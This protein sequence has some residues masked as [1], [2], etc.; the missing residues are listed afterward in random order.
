MPDLSKNQISTSLVST[1][2]ASELSGYNSDYL[3]RV[4]REGKIKGTQVGRAWLIDKESLL[5]FVESQQERKRELAQQT[6]KVREQEYKTANKTTPV[7][8]GVK[9]ATQK[10]TQKATE[11]ARAVISPIQRSHFSGSA[12]GVQRAHATRVNRPLVAAA[13]ALV[14]T[15]G[16]AYASTAPQLQEMLARMPENIQHVADAVMR[17]RVIDDSFRITDATP[18]QKIVAAEFAVPNAK[19]IS[20]G[21]AYATGAKSNTYAQTF[22]AASVGDSNNSDATFASHFSTEENA[23]VA[24][25]RIALVTDAIAH[26]SHM[27]VSLVQGYVQ[28]GAN[29]FATAHTI[30]D[31]YL[32]MV[33][34]VADSSLATAAVARDVVANA[35]TNTNA[36]LALYERGTYAWVDASH[37]V[38]EVSAGTIYNTGGTIGGL[39]TAAPGAIVH[40]R[41]AL[42]NAWVDRSLAL[43]NAAADSQTAAGT[44]A[45][46]VAD[47]IGSSYLGA[48]DTSGNVVGGAL[49][50][51]VAALPN[52]SEV[53][54]VISAPAQQAVATA[55]NAG[56]TLAAAVPAMP[57]HVSFSTISD[58]TQDTMLGMAG[59]VMAWAD[60]NSGNTQSASVISFAPISWQRTIQR[61]FVAG[62]EIA[63]ALVHASVR[64]IADTFSLPGAFSPE[65][66]VVPFGPTQTIALPQP[67]NLGGANGVALGNDSSSASGSY[68]GGA[69]GP[70]TYIQN[71]INNFSKDAFGTSF[72]DAVLAI[73][74]PY[75]Q[76]SIDS[77]I[78]SVRS[79]GGG[80]TT[81]VTGSTPANVVVQGGSA[82]LASLDVSG[83]T[84]LNTLTTTGVTTLATTTVNGDLNIT[85]TISAGSLAVS[86]ITSN[87]PVIAP[88]FT[89]TSTVATSTFPNLAA[90]NADITNATLGNATST[91]FFTTN[92]S[93]AAAN[94]TNAVFGS[95]VANLANIT[96]ATITNLTGTNS[97]FVNSTTTNATTTNLFA[98]NGVINNAT[99]T[100]LF[101]TNVSGTNATFGN[102][103]TTNLFAT[104]AS[105][106]TGFFDNLFATNAQFVNSTTT[107]ATTTNF[108]ATNGFINTLASAVANIA[109]A[110][111]T[112]LTGTNSQFVNSTTTNSVATNATTTNLTATNASL[113]NALIT[114]GTSTN[115][116]ATNLTGTN[117]QFTNA[118]STNFFSTLGSFT[119]AIFGSFVA[120]LANI[121]TA[122]IT[123]LSGTNSVFVNATTT[124]ATTT[125]LFATNATTTNLVTSNLTGTSAQFTHATTSD[126]A[127]TGTVGSNLI[128]SLNNQ[129]DIGSP[130][131]TWSNGYFDSIHVANFFVASTS[132]DGTASNV[133]SINSDNATADTE[134]SSISF[135]RGSISPNALLT[136]NSTLDRFEFNMPVQ[137]PSLTASTTFTLGT[138]TF[139]SLLGAG[140]SNVGGALT[141]TV[142][143]TSLALDSSYFK[144][145]G[146][147]FGSTAILG[148]TDNNS[149]NI[150]TNNSVAG[151]FLANGFL[152][153]GTT[154]PVERLSV[155]GNALISGSLKAASLITTGNA[156]VNS[157]TI[158]SLSGF[159][160][161]TAGAVST[162]LVDLSTDVTST[163]P[164]GNGGT[165]ATSLTG[166]LV[167]NGTGAFTATT[168]SSG[169]ASQ[170]SD[171]TGT[172][173]LVFA[174]SPTFGG[175]AI[176]NNV[177]ATSATSTNF[178]ST[179]T[180]ITNLT[181]TNL[182]VG[183]STFTSLLGSGL[184]NVGGVLTATTSTSTLALDSQYFKQG[185]NAF[186]AL[187][188]LGT[189]DNNALIFETNSLER[190]RINTSGQ[191]VSNIASSAGTP[192][193]TWSS[194]LTTGLFHPA[195]NQIGFSTGGIQRAVIDGNGNLGL[196]TTTP[197]AKLTIIGDLSLSGGIYDNNLTRGTLGQILQTT[198]TGVQW[199]GTST[200]GLQPAG[201]YITALTGDVS[202]SGPGSAAATLATVNS[203]TG[204][205]G[206]STAIPTF[207]VNGK[208]LITAAGSVAVI[209]PAGTLTGTTLASN[210]VSSSLTSVGTLT[211]L[212]VSGATTL[213][214]LTAALATTT[215]LTTTN[216]I[217]GGSTFTSLLGSG[218]SNVGGTLSV[219]TSSLALDTTYFKQN[220]N[221]F[222]ATA[223]LGTNDNNDLVFKTNSLERLRVNTSGQLVSNIASAAGTP[224]FTWTSDLTTGIFHPANNNVAIS[225]GGIERLRVDGNGFIGV[226]TT[227]A[228][229]TLT[230]AGDIGLTGALYAGN[231]SAGTAG[232]ILQTTGTGIQWTSTS[233]LGLQPSGN[234]ITALTGDISATGP[235][236]AA[237]TLATVNSN[238][239]SFGS[240]TA[241]PTFTVNGKGL[242][243]AA[244]T[245]VVIAPAGTLTGTTLASN[246]LASS[247]TSVGTLSSLTV[248]GTSALGNL[249][250]ALATTTSLTTTNFIL[251]GSTFTS[252]LGTGLVNTAGVLSISTSSLALDTNY[253]KQGGNSF[254]AT[255]QLG[256][257]DN[258]DLVFQTNNV[259]RLRIN[260]SGQLVS[261]IASAAGTPAFTW[262]SDLTTGIF[263]PA[264]NNIGFT[265][266]GIQR[267]VIDGNGN[268]GVGTSSPSARLTVKGVGTTTGINFQ[269]TNSN[270]A[271]LFTILDN[272]NVGIGTTSP[273]VAL[274]LAS[275]TASTQLRIESGQNT[276]LARIQFLNDLGTTA[277][278][279]YTGSANA[280]TAIFSIPD[281]LYLNG[282]GTGGVTINAGGA[283]GVIR[284]A[285]GGTAFSN[286]RLRI[287]AAGNVGIGSTTPLSTLSV[288][289]TGITNPFT[290]ASSSGLSLFSINPSGAALFNNQ[291]GSIGTVL[292]SFG[293]GAA[294]QWVSTSTLGFASGTSLGSANQVAYYN[295]SGVLGGTAGFIFDGTNLSVGGT[296]TAT[297]QHIGIGGTGAAGTPSYT[298]ASDLT[299]GIFHPASNNIGFST[300]GI[301]RAVIDG[302][303]NFGIATTSPLAKLD[304]YG[305]AGTADIFA[306]SSSS[307][308][309]LFT[310]TSGGNVGI[311]TSSPATK[312]SI[313]AAAPSI[314]LNNTTSGGSA[315]LIRNGSIGNTRFDIFDAK[316][317]ISMLTIDRNDGN[318]G[319]VMIGTSSN[320]APGNNSRL[321][322]YGGANGANIDMM[323]DPSLSGGIGDQSQ[324]EAEGAD[325]GLG[326]LGNTNSIAIRYFGNSFPNALG[327]WAGVT[328]HNTG[329]LD[330]GTA[331]N[332]VIRT[333]TSTPIIVGINNVE[334]LRF[335]SLGLSIGTTS[336]FAALTL[337]GDL[338]ISGG[339]YDRSATRGTSGQI[340]QTTG[341][342]V[343][344]VGTST[345]GL[346]PA[347]NYITALTGDITATGP[348]SVAATLATVNSNTGSFGSSTAI[349]NFTVNGKGLI[350]AAGSSAV[351]A[352]AGT[353][354]GTTLA[355]NVVS[356]S[357]T[358]VGTLTALTVSGATTLGNLTAALATTTSLTTTNF[359]LGGSTFTSLLGTGLVNTGGTLTVSTTSNALGFDTTYFKQ[360]G[361]AF[362]GLATL[363]T[364]DS[365]AL[366]FITGGTERAR[367]DTS[368]NFGIGTTTPN[369]LL[370]VSGSDTSTALTTFDP[371]VALSIVNR[372]TTNNTFAA[373]AFRTQDLTNNSATSTAQILGINTSH[374]AGRASGALAFQT[375]NSGVLSEV[376]RITN[377]G[378]VGIGITIP[379]SIL[380]VFEATPTVST[381]T[382]GTSATSLLTINGGFGGDT[383]SSGSSVF[384]GNGATIT[385]VTGTGGSVTGNPTTGFAGTGGD[386]IVSAGAGGQITGLPTSGTGGA[387]GSIN[388]TAGGGGQGFTAD[389]IAGNVNITGG[390]SASGVGG[391]GTGGGYVSISGGAGGGSGLNGGNVY[392]FGGGPGF[393]SSAGNV[394]LGL[395]P[396]GTV[397]AN[398]GVGTSSPVAKLDVYGTAGTAD[399]F[400]ISSSS[401]SRL[402]TISSAGFVGIGSSTPSKTLSITGDL[403]LSGGFFDSLS[404]SGSNGFVL[405]STGSA[406]KWVATSTLGFSSGGGATAAGTS[407][408][409][410]YFNG[411]SSLVGTSGFTFDGTNLSVGGTITATGQYI[412][413][414]GTGV[415]GTPSYSFTGDLTTGIF[416]PAANTLAFSTN[417]TERGRFDSAGNF[418]IGSSTPLSTLSVSGTGTTNP[419][420][421]ASSSGNSLLTVLSNGNVGI[422]SSTPNYLLS[423]AGQTLIGSAGF[424]TGSLGATFNTYTTDLNTFSLGSSFQS[425]GS[426]NAAGSFQSLQFNVTDS[427][428]NNVNTM[429]GLNGLAV[430]STSGSVTALIAIQ[431]SPRLTGTATAITMEGYRSQVRT[432]AGTAASTTIDFSATAA[433]SG[434]VITSAYGVRVVSKKV[435]GVVTGYGIGTDGAT[436]LNY[437]MG[438]TGVGTTSPAAKLDVYGAAGTADIFAISSSSN[439]RLL[440]VTSSG[441][442]GIGTSTPSKKLTVS[443]DEYLTGGF[444]DSTFSAGTLGMVLQSTGTST[445]WVATSTLGISGTN[446]FTNS[447]ASTYLSTGTNL[448]IGTST[449]AARLDVYGVGG[450]ADIFTISSSSNSRLLTVTSSGNLGVGSSSPFARLTVAGSG[451][452]AATTN[453]QTT[454]SS[455]SPL[456]TILDNGNVGIATSTPAD[457]LAVTGGNIVQ[458]VSTGASVKGTLINSAFAGGIGVVVSG[459]YAYIAASSAS[460]VSI[461]DISNPTAPTLVGSV[462][463]ATNLAGVFGIAVSGKY[464]Y[465][466]ANN[467]QRVTVVD[468]SNP[469]A[470][471][472]VSNLSDSTNLSQPRGIVV[473]GKYAYVGATANNRITVVD[474]SNP[475]ALKVVGTIQDATNLAGTDGVFIQGKYLYT[476]PKDG[477]MMSIVDISNPAT[478]VLVGHSTNDA[479][480]TNN[481]HDVYVVGKYA[482][483]VAQSSHS[484]T[485]FDISDPTSP[486]RITT[487]IDGTNLASPKHVYVAGRY[488]YVTDNGNSRL[489]TIDISNAAAPVV[490][491]SIADG[492]NLVQAR[493]IFVTGKYAVIAMNTGVS[494][495]SVDGIDSPGGSFGNVSAQTL[496]ATY[497]AQIGGSIF[498]NG[499]LNVGG[500]I[501]SDGAL[502]VLGGGITASTSAADFRNASG[503]PLLLVRNDGNVGIGTTTP[504]SQLTTTGT[505]QFAN[506]GSAGATVT[507]DANG[508]IS[509]SSD[510]RLK[511]INGSFSR[512]LADI[513]KL[514]PILY[515][516]NAVSGLDQNGQYAGFSA[517]NVQSAIPEAVATDNRGY[518]TLADR[519]IIA[520]SVNAIK[521]L[522]GQTG[523]LSTTTASL[524]GRLASVE[525]ANVAAASAQQ[526][527]TLPHALT[528]TEITAQSLTIAE[529]V[530]AGTLTTH[531]VNA[532]GTVSAARYIVPAAAQVFTTGSTTMAAVLPAEALTEDGMNVDVFKLASYAVASVQVLATRTDLLATRIDEIDSRVSALESASTATSSVSQDAQG[533]LGLAAAS[534]QHIFESFGI[535]IR[536]GIAQFTTLVT[537]Q[538]VFS[539]DTNGT[540]SAASVV[541]PS[542]QTEF[543]VNNTLILPTSKIFLTFTSSVNGSWYIS[544]KEAGSFTVTLASA[545]SADVTFDYFLV[546]TEGQIAS[547]AAPLGSTPPP[548]IPAPTDGSNGTT[549]NPAPVSQDGG[550]TVSLSGAAAVQIPQGA[551]W[552]DPGATATAADGTDL[553]SSIAVSGGVD[554]NTPGLYTVTYRATDAA[555]KFGEASR[556]VTV[557]GAPTGSS[558]PDS[559]TP[560]TTPTVTA[561]PADS[562]GGA[563]T[564]SPSDSAPSAAAPDPTPAS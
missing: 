392:V 413:I 304:V 277:S 6:A 429:Q 454:N 103:T 143:T 289:G 419:F 131:A 404:S 353:L 393:A 491:G 346:Q 333:S 140:L 480:N 351:I 139:S 68:T 157:L 533:V 278:V 251:G 236:S 174:T 493:G 363:G 453:F 231:T 171:E 32:A 511:N 290:I 331:S 482:Y 214:N 335:T 313:Q 212:T 339:I 248:S 38:A 145:G 497:D 387:G 473:S 269:T 356:S 78:G 535:F 354:T 130:G 377:T 444:F 156:N 530:S 148:T 369:S 481:P 276:G 516:W 54:P 284:F 435:T 271:A 121:T 81:V 71:I 96:S 462:V 316:N 498:A 60:T 366:R 1:K 293:A 183:G 232:Q 302:N 547:V 430:K 202:A 102:A 125:N 99:S 422:G 120:T 505:V 449:P 26:P 361:N 167:G 386:F 19:N 104:I 370:E 201:N 321:F 24:H 442:L 56:H 50:S 74:G 513:E 209:A 110:V 82:S 385:L 127:V 87:G 521:E 411:A 441:N 216:F 48:V 389:G 46:A 388:L 66:A 100:N 357:L 343:Q 459:K 129:Y 228:S 410:A 83:S 465:V 396:S 545:Q 323:G 94:I 437:F 119:N 448:G 114:N 45:L 111:I 517:Q 61:I 460:A 445:L 359:I 344:W 22:A 372:S 49:A 519:P 29:I 553:T 330:F 113:T 329:V 47:S 518:L 20:R 162:A 141:V 345:L 65:L 464:A 272:G 470:P 168:L 193:F 399:I 91:N 552:T 287:D 328:T 90:T 17:P 92:L 539:S 154:S 254:G 283:S 253:F 12:R 217:L 138:S 463:D 417:G 73:V 488:A 457:R 543:K 325:W 546:Q 44:K 467:N 557:I 136:W 36:L 558:T 418:G 261:N 33:Y 31:T 458:T 532:D 151:T 70:T 341:T 240:S 132:I 27:A 452:T 312:L 486:T 40:A 379:T 358:S 203:N 320:S 270:N 338:S 223:S 10:A 476:T 7:F 439:S 107:N 424:P 542:G 53:S 85:G 267:A 306:I 200:L 495:M 128:P 258:N 408:Q 233:T 309:R 421:V 508:N 355:S 514:S 176:F 496:V 41:E 158:G 101:A 142:S 196:G 391:A 257:I 332:A 337:G 67:T 221:S 340:L 58:L 468:I 134:D 75:V 181:A 350:T 34:G 311:G 416:H 146:N 544:K 489:T 43:A 352:P 106:V 177:T 291:A 208:G 383:S 380:S 238:T 273:V 426:I 280:N 152:G 348:G 79:N 520:A 373:L 207:T 490:V 186:G 62:G 549:P 250:A 64:A 515:H 210:V 485:I 317:N 218:L 170:I 561:G 192:A 483:V 398:I 222:G 247:L 425:T 401:N 9:N 375:L 527:A 274:H 528:A 440:T 281:Q 244:G 268:L 149:L 474:I 279:A 262:T 556:I 117:A 536:E 213:G 526:D 472:V 194:D 226:G 319:Q 477:N 63:Q 310:V 381:T 259:E 492:T 371:A 560:P 147:S 432:P 563:G 172:G 365:N 57:E 294:P 524:A 260:T 301:Q 220:G 105:A 2:I 116:A 189:T 86:S 234:Y 59:K 484:F 163:L 446:Y 400:A 431:A 562:G 443:G 227:T 298:F 522:A 286:E 135:D 487:L 98:T 296:I 538:L 219:S 112:N 245:V 21:F 461:V 412:G 503:T 182:T 509:V 275:S 314:T 126:F 531:S 347:G 382:T 55:Q 166:L 109:S 315:F 235:G 3:G 427:G 179:N 155:A 16:T 299:T 72:N 249:T 451:T 534:I 264:S 564:A 198:G 137:A 478:P 124:N 144:Q 35:P 204:S 133:F 160:K 436:D 265:T 395:N 548:A 52:A 334:T 288:T 246:V 550:P 512:G 559:G 243:T 423:V 494:V 28:T 169:I 241:I 456:F 76:H 307:N 504:G 184:A 499:S 407:G 8:D 447:G 150:L 529:G 360:N 402:L 506:Y 237:A 175:T 300:G 414:G 242:I 89:A 205:F 165:G 502:S 326:A 469:K 239:G 255:A 415:P 18:A 292:Q 285:T 173:A 4:C 225:T 378:R 428:G 191:L 523:A 540:S 500:G 327:N 230:V 229:R 397:R 13:V 510:E 384:A 466:T 206:S 256:T 252:L 420:T 199:V 195:I 403:S 115:F 555:G 507:T 551:S 80:G 409:V 305:T 406:T 405:Q 14:F 479:T 322:V 349:P 266:G 77:A 324:V 197:F 84:T 5:Q 364:T 11:A 295:S 42:A 541:I 51:A 336:A 282:A 434:G 450:T 37:T 108:F 122:T 475:Y 297:G 367:F 187:A 390:V 25:T 215:S 433:T 185:G 190:I 97:Q 69:T 342:G 188:T 501:K 39:A 30:G 123:N 303:G 178:A 224:A 525:A 263:H 471:V 95:F 159:L 15:A 180:A 438:S 455:N 23:R 368:G 118:T 88:Y 93:A 374:T 153:L 394:V 362:A 164:V 318:A 161:A 537:H 376:M 211:A 554:T 308:A